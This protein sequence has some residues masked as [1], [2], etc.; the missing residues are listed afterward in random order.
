MFWGHLKALGE[1][2]RAFPPDNSTNHLSL[3]MVDNWKKLFP[4]E[5]RCPTVVYLDLWPVSKS[6]MFTLHPKVSAQF[7]QIKSLPKDEMERDFLKPLTGN[8]DMV[9]SDGEQWKKWRSI[10]NPGFSPR[11]IT[12]LVPAMMEDMLTFLSVLESYAGSATQPGQVI[13]LE[14][15]TTNLTF[16]IIAKATLYV[17]GSPLAVMVHILLS[18]D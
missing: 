5:T 10:F 11:N 16:D 6:I 12:S 4:A 14:K 2:S 1:Y 13:Q 17:L 15:L 8:K 18:L 7:T 9:S 3:W